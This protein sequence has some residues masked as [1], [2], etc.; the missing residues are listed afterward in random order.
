M[1]YVETV[2]RERA[3][4]ALARIY[5]R[6]VRERGALAAIHQAASVRPD[7]VRAHYAF[8]R[9]LMFSRT[10][11]SRREREL[12]AVAVSEANACGY[13][14]THHGEALCRLGAGEA[15][16]AES[17]REAALVRFAR[18]LTREPAA[19][20]QA[21]IEALSAAGLGDAQIVDA[22]FVTGYFAMANRIVYGLGVELEPDYA[23]SCR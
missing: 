21:D 18:R 6:I 13:C 17:A 23:R 10:G 16:P 5:D 15:E 7:L 2:A 8:Y 3:Q 12:I 20:G 22:V 11:L 14:A 1:A 19:I 9:R 4:G